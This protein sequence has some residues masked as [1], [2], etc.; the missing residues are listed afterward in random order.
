LVG[1]RCAVH[2]AGDRGAGETMLTLM[3]LHPRQCRHHHSRCFCLRARRTANS[4]THPSSLRR[5]GEN[6]DPSRSCGRI[7]GFASRKT[8][9]PTVRLPLRIPKQTDHKPAVAQSLGRTRVIFGATGSSCAIH[10]DQGRAGP[11]ASSSNPRFLDDEKFDVRSWAGRARAG[12]LRGLRRSEASA[13]LSVEDVCNRRPGG[14]L[15]PHE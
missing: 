11:A 5:I 12:W 3:S 13:R 6:E 2:S 15:E 9:F 8:A 1:F 4:T 7:G 14:D 10:P